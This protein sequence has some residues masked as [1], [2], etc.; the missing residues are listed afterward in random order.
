MRE[1]WLYCIDMYVKELT[2]DRSP[3]SVESCC[4]GLSSTPHDGSRVMSA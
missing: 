4:N 3:L 1:Q 2:S